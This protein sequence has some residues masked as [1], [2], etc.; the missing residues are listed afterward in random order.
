VRC[1]P[2]PGGMICTS[3]RNLKCQ[4]KGCGKGAVALCD[5]LLEP[6]Q[7]GTKKRSCD[8]RLCADHRVRVGDN[9]DLCPFH[10]GPEHDAAARQLTLRGLP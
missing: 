4:V 10:A 1:Q 5:H 3:R 9:R 6:H 8:A 7:R 2:I